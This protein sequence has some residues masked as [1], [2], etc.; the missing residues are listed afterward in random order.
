MTDPLLTRP[1]CPT[2]RVAM[3]GHLA[4]LECPRCLAWEALDRTRK[5]IGDWATCTSVE[6]TDAMVD[7][8]RDDLN[9]KTEHVVSQWHADCAED[10]RLEAKAAVERERKREVA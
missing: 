3:G 4:V 6:E 8:L 10:A 2:C 7:D 5:S 1:E 9:N